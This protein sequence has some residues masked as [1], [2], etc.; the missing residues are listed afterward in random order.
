MSLIERA[1]EKHRRQGDK[2]PAA[3]P[4]LAPAAA[5][6]EVLSAHRELSV[7]PEIVELDVVQ[8]RMRG[9]MPAEEAMSE[10]MHQFRRLKRPLVV[11]ALQRDA[12]TALS[13]RI[14]AV[15][16]AVAGEGKSF[17]SLNLAMSLAIERDFNVL[18]IDGDIARGALT[19]A[20]GLGDQ[21][22]L[23]DLLSEADRTMESCVRRTSLEGLYV[24]PCGKWRDNAPELLGS[25]RLKR[26]L[27]DVTARYPG[28]LVVCDTA[29][30]ML[31]NE[32]AVFLSIAG[33][34][35]FIVSSGSTPRQS[36]IDSLALI[37]G[38]RA[39]SMVLNKFSGPVDSGY[40]YY[41]QHY[42]AR[43]ERGA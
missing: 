14:I 39:I 15:A 4:P 37:P 40:Q 7:G 13:S 41:G 32:G 9:Y 23:L 27:S 36:V 8:L 18:L 5:V 6:S 21:P 25:T 3:R 19:S 2:Q 20:L 16:S 22:G 43:S 42:D 1:L 26:L 17:T 24:L 12:G 38:D 11:N 31:T 29:P 30:V 34:V 33:Q 35:V 28:C 10:M